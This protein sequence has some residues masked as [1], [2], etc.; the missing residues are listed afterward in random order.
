MKTDTPVVHGNATG[1]SS[2]DANAQ[3][4]MKEST[5]KLVNKNNR[6]VRNDIHHQL[7]LTILKYHQTSVFLFCTLVNKFIKPR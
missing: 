4:Q 1:A 5:M 6:F 7:I 2:I 3:V